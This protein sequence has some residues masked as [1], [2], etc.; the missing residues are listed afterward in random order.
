MAEIGVRELKTRASEIVKSVRE[1]G[2][3]YLVTYRGKA[4]GI[5][6]PLD[7]AEA[8]ETYPQEAIAWKQLV[9]L[10]EKI[11]RDW[12]SPMTSAELLSEMRR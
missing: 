1:Q 12:Q 5:L 7:K 10:G 8:G 11:G 6:M 9:E 3:R 2:A 4:V